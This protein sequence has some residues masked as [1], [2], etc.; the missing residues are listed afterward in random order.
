MQ[1]I[2]YSDQVFSQQDHNMLHAIMIMGDLYAVNHSLGVL[3]SEQ[4]MLCECIC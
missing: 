3:C 1:N 2:S 4:T